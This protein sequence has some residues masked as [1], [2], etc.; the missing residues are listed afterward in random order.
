[1]TSIVDDI[2]VR[3][4]ADY[5][6]TAT[7]ATDAINDVRELLAAVE[8]LRADRD[9]DRRELARLR[10]EVRKARVAATQARLGR[11]PK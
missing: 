8:Q 4:L 1:M 9:A 10:E 6:Q 3:L 11:E 5:A 2:R 7:P